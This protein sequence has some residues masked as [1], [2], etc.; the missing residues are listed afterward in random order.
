[1]LSKFQRASKEYQKG[2]TAYARVL[3]DEGEKF[4]F[5]ALQYRGEEADKIFSKNNP[6][7]VLTKPAPPHVYVQSRK[8]NSF[9]GTNEVTDHFEMNGNELPPMQID[10]HGL[11]QQEALLHVADMY[12]VCKKNMSPTLVMKKDLAECAFTKN[13]SL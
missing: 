13:L 12:K 10:L 1:M 5:M 7:I 11:H 9:A 2:N 4:R 3:A 8:G 6:D